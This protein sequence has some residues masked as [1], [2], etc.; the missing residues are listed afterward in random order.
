M[1]VPKSKRRRRPAQAPK[2]GYRF[3]AV[4][5]DQID[6]GPLLEALGPPAQTGR[7]A[8][9]ARAMLRAV[10][11]KF[12][13][14]HKFNLETL[15]RLRASP[16]FREV[17][18]FPGPVP[19]ESTYSRFTTK[20]LKHQD[21]LDACVTKIAECLRD[22]IPTLGETVAVDS[23]SIESFSNPNRKIVSD[24]EARWGFR[25]KARAKEEG[26]EW[27][28]G[29]KLHLLADA[30]WGVPLGYRVVPANQHDSP[31]LPKL[32]KDSRER[33]PWWQPMFVLGDRGYD[34]ET[35]HQDVVATGAVPII[36]MRE[37]TALDGLF[38][39]IYTVKGEPTC[40]GSMPMEY[41]ETDAT[42]GHHRF[43]C[44]ESGCH[45]K[46]SFSGAVRHCD[47]EVW[48]DPMERLRIVGLL[49]RA[50]PEWSTHYSKRMDIER[51]FRSLKHS[52]GLEGHRVRGLAKI[53]L[54]ATLSMLSYSATVLARFQV[55][56][57]RNARI[58]RVRV[59]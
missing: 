1:A 10:L 44:P 18:G 20:L 30:D 19:S 3:L 25:H 37:T 43:R 45:L 39:G 48:E 17:C 42:T 2:G 38:D 13:L 47:T 54:L 24:P 40:V 11:S 53:K 14:I 35:N 26:T 23:T 56:D 59:A 15:E 28:F 34:A 12:I 51:L 5:L 7:H 22:V 55:G 16:K 31:M 49:A 36:H 58:M 46:E 29:Y 9:P 6:D 50:S 57:L 41:V 32:L 8:F 4:I 33:N 27:V 21:L 52:R